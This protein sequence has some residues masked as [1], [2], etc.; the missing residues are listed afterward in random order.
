V[1]YEQLQAEREMWEAVTRQERRPTRDQ[2]RTM[3]A[4]YAGTCDDCGRRIRR[5]DHIAYQPL[6][7]RGHKV[8]CDTCA[9]KLEPTGAAA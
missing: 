8:F 3:R 7:P 5:G 4:R 6:A 1:T 9:A 2:Y